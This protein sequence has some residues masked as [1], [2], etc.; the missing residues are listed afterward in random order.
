MSHI[1]L[2]VK[3]VQFA[4]LEGHVV[5][6]EGEELTVRTGA[7]TLA[8]RRALS[9]MLAPAVGDTVLV[10]SAGDAH[11]I[12]AVLARHTDAAVEFHAQGDLR[13]RVTGGRFTVVAD[14][15]V[16]LATSKTLRLLASTLS[17]QAVRGDVWIDQ[18][19]HVGSKLHAEIERVKT[20]CASL[21]QTLDRWS[22]RVKRAYRR[23]EEID[24]VRAGQV[25]IAAD[26]TLRAHGQNAVL[27]SEN[28]LKLDGEQI[29]LG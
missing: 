24:Q 28:L 12:T 10:A 23:V 22:Q 13:V 29:H 19:S 27:T 16:E 25:D 9:C 2:A 6:A 5:S 14:D 20:T 21:D 15:G 17:A 26:T 18:L 1:A 4:Q 7:Q 3:D 8:A 11:W